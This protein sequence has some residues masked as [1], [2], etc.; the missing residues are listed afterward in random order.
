MKLPTVAESS[1]AILCSFAVSLILIGAGTS[2]HAENFGIV[3]DQ[4]CLTLLKNNI[5]TDCPTYED[6]ITFFPDKSNRK[7]SGDFGYNHG[8]YQR[9]PTKFHNS[10]EYYR[11]LPNSIIFIDPPS[12]YK[13]R[14]KLIEIKA[15]FE[16]Y[17]MPR[18]QGYDNEAYALITGVG[19]YV[20]KCN[21]AYI[22]ATNW[23]FL[24]G[25]SLKFLG[26]NC[27]PSSTNF[28]STRTT[29][30]Q[31]VTHDIT[32]SYKYKL[33]AW[34]KES[35]LKCGTKLCLYVRNQTSPP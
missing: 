18:L 3:L 22:A 8:I 12:E 10:F 28:N 27:D 7:I 5:T 1:L 25:D 31:K 35:L 11:T 16:E 34:Q 24:L 2:A 30:M 32:T 21:V 29:Y 4:T 14:I 20:S 26:S 13:A 19:R 9:L 6:I 33:E 23:V 15:N 17:K